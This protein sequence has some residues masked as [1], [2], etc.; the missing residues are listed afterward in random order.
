MFSLYNLG[1]V[2]ALGFYFSTSLGDVE[3]FTQVCR[4]PG[5]LERKDKVL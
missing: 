3:S 4:V 1:R 2:T 5:V